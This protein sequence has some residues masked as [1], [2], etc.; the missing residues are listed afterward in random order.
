[1]VDEIGQEESL[2][3]D[4]RGNPWQAA[5]TGLVRS[6]RPYRFGDPTRLIHW[7][8]SARYGEL[9]VR[10]L[11]IIT[12]G[13]EIIIALD[14][15]AHWEADDFEQAVTTAVS[16]YFYTQHQ[17]LLAQMWTAATGL[18]RGE[19][20]VLETLA[21]IAPLED[22]RTPPEN[23]PLIWLTPNSLSL[24]TLPLGSR[25]ILWQNQHPNP[26]KLVCSRDYPGVVIQSDQELLP[27]LQ[28]SPHQLSP[29][30][31]PFF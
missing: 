26:E 13:Q 30:P 24:S 25:W 29:H 22:T 18:I 12:G 15:S 8:T 11:E 31:T 27:Q 3:G 28:K 5:T 23:S 17:R 14:S 1:L 20:E 16:L 6:L 19:R 9:R 2:Q 4:P 21:A 7:R 10:E